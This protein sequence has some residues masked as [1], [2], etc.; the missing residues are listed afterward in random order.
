MIAGVHTEVL[1]A[2]GYATFL[3]GVAFVLE[4]LARQSHRRSELYRNAGFV[5]RHKVDLWECPVGRQLLRAE[6]DYSRRIVRYRAPAQACNACSLKNNCTDSNDGRLLEAG[7]LAVGWQLLPYRN[8]EG[9]P[10]NHPGS[11]Q[12]P[13]PGGPMW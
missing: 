9:F 12:A 6:T 8:T 7:H 10:V 2:V 3:A 1:L 4:F 5:Y 11:P 13:R